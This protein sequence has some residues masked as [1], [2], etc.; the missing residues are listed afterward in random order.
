MLQ[1]AEL[2]NRLVAFDPSGGDAAARR[3]ARATAFLPDVALGPDGLLWVADQ[4]LPGAGPAPLRSRRP[5][6]SS[7]DG[8]SRVGLPPFSIGFVP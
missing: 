2:A 1:D 8:R 3:S 6:G 4:G 5:T 7:R